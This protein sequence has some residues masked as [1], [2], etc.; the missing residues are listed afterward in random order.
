M[1]IFIKKNN[2]DL[3]FNLVY[4]YYNFN[5]YF[6]IAFFL[7]Y[8]YIV[9]KFR[10]ESNIQNKHQLISM[11]SQFHSQGSSSTSSNDSTISGILLNNNICRNY[12]H[13]TKYKNVAKEKLI[14]MS[15]YSLCYIISKYLIKKTL[16]FLHEYL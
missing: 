14:M 6:F 10:H 4:A 1:P 3:I 15:N 8:L 13:L 7:N 2:F 16:I 12:Y 9:N 11:D 5:T